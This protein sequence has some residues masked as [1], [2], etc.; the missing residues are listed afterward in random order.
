VINIHL[1]YHDFVH[2]KSVPTPENSILKSFD[3]MH[4]HSGG[5]LGTNSYHSLL[6]FACSHTAPFAVSYWSLLSC[7]LVIFSRGPRRLRSPRTI[8]S[9]GSFQ[10]SYRDYSRGSW[11]IP[12]LKDSLFICFTWPVVHS[13]GLPQT[14]SSFKRSQWSLPAT[15]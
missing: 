13:I 9:F 10:R 1:D 6:G 12:T 4:S 3:S 11:S 5:P 8:N 7:C 15:P 2:T 14:F